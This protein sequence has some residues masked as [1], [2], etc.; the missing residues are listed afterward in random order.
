VKLNETVT[1]IL[2]SLHVVYVDGKLS[3][4]VISWAE[5]SG[6]IVWIF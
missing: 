6:G 4:G 5:Y 2:I 3:S 1:E